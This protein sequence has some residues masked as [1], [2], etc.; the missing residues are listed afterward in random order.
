MIS[1]DFPAGC[2]VGLVED[3]FIFIANQISLDE[4]LDLPLAIVHVDR[5]HWKSL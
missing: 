4:T 5:S 2:K 3:S 1:P